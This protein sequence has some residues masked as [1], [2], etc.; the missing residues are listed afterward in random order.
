M[1]VCNDRR[2]SRRRAEPTIAAMPPNPPEDLRTTR[3]GVRAFVLDADGVLLYR[4]APIPGSTEAL[5][6]LR[7]RGIPY[8]VVTNFSLTHRTTLAAQFSKATGLPAEPELIITAASAAA[9]YTR[10]HHPGGRLLVLASPDAAREWDGQQLVSP[11][12]ADTGS[13]PVDA[14]VIGDAGDALSFSNLDIAFRQLR[15]GA[16]F[17]AMHRNPWWVTPKGPTLDSGALVMGLEAAL[18]RKAVVCGKPSP[19]VFRE[20]LGQL[21]G[22]TVAA[23]GERLL[24]SQVGMVGDDPRADV[25]AAKRVGLLGFLVLTGKVDAAAAAAAR[26]RPDAIA[27]SLAELVAHLP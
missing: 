15:A 17:I 25:A 8:R 13:D 20:A 26:P 23:G 27:A 22:D 24:A 19:V 7:A 11:E 12:A 2:A 18:G 21:R 10:R 6:T 5:Q 9:D 16:A 3:A 14:V 4:G 1:R